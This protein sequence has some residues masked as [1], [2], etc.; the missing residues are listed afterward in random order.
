[1]TQKNQ[2][3]ARDVRHSDASKT[4]TGGSADTRNPDWD[5]Y[6]PEGHGRT[7]EQ[8]RADVQEK[9]ST[10]KDLSATS[11]AL[12]IVV[13]DGRVTL[14]GEVASRGVQQ[15]LLDLIRSVPSV[16]GVESKLRVVAQ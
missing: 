10:E 15:R 12:A 13:A 1:M 6:V 5:S 14:Q 3:S 8:I 11:T 4:G 9:L 2:A 7:D 16:K